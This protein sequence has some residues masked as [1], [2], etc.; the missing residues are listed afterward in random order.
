[1]KGHILKGR[2]FY[3]VLRNCVLNIRYRQLENV[4]SVKAE[5]LGSAKVNP[6]FFLK[7]CSFGV[8][9]RISYV[10]HWQMFLKIYFMI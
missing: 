7:M 6:I 8:E 5:G 4:I 3:V 1:M 2:H 10:M 9:C